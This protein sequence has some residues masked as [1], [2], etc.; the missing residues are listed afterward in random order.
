MKCTWSA[1][2]F[3]DKEADVLDFGDGKAKEGLD[4]EDGF[5]DGEG[6]LEADG[7]LHLRKG[8]GKDE[9][10]HHRALVTKRRGRRGRRRRRSAAS[11]VV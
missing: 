7:L 5:L 10:E 4:G 8:L 3:G 11:A 6:G 2:L 9:L 1:A